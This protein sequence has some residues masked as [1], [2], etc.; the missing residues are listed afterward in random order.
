VADALAGGLDR[1]PLLAGQPGGA[2]LGA[3]ALP[4]ALRVPPDQ[5]PRLDRF[6]RA[7]HAV[8]P[9][10]RG[11]QVVA[12]HRV[13]IELA[14]RGECCGGGIQDGPIVGGSR[15]DQSS[16]GARCPHQRGT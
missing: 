11:A 4:H 16:F 5:H 8:E 2:G 15:H 9:E 6:E 7:P 3:G 12:A 10:H 14:E 13:E 1:D